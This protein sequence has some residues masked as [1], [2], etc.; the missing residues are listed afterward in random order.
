MACKTLAALGAVCAISGAAMAQGVPM[1][2]GTGYGQGVLQAL[3][4]A[5]GEDS[6]IAFNCSTAEFQQG[7]SVS[8]QVAG[9][10]PEGRHTLQLTVDGQTLPL[11]LLN[12]VVNGN[13]RDAGVQTAA[14][15]LMTSS[16]PTFT[17]QIPDLNWRQEFPLANARTA[18]REP[19][20]NTIV[21][22]CGPRR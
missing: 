13:D 7:P 5:P 14:R 9:R 17:A 16:S 15:A 12:G 20:G 1:G 8:V 4:R 11:P 6:Y 19:S 18:L 3:V 10:P 22:Q 2:W 21:D